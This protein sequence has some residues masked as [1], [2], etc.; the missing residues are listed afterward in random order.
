VTAGQ[1][2]AAP[3]GGKKQFDNQRNTSSGVV[4]LGGHRAGG[5]AQAYS[6]IS[7]SELASL[8]DKRP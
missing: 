5:Y 8:R 2:V 1:T 3:I 4:G 7:A 6:T